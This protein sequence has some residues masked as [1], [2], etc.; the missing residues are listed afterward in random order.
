M[1]LLV[2]S[3]YVAITTIP[4]ASNFSPSLYSVLVGGVWIF[5]STTL[6]FSTLIDWFTLFP[7]NVIVTLFCPTFKFVPF[8]IL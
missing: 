3:L 4:D 6:F 2:P 1:H 5:K 7:L 8:V